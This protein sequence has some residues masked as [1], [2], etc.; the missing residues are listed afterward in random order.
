M[1]SITK[2]NLLNLKKDIQDTLKSLHLDEKEIRIKFLENET[3]SS[4]FWKD[5]NNA[6]GILSEIERLK[7]EIETS[8]TLSDDIEALIELIEQIDE[9]DYVSLKNDIEDLESRYNKFQILKF[10]S[11][12]Y[13]ISGAVLTIHAG[14]GGTEANDW[15][16]MLL[17]MYT[18]FAERSGWKS[19]LIDLVPGT[20]TGVS[21]ATLQIEGEYV[22]GKL[23]RETGTHRLVR[24]S[25]FNAQNLRQTSFAGIEVVPIIS[26]ND[27]EVEIKEE[28]LDIKAV[29]AGGAGG[30]HVNK[31]SSAIQ[32]KHIP[33]GIT[34]HSSSRREQL[35]NKQAALQILK[36]KLWQIEEEKRENELKNIKGEHKIAGWGNQ[37]RNYVLHPYKLVKDLRTDIQSSNPFDV[38]DGNLD[39]FVDAQTR[40]G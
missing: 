7:K 37:I 40:I 4:D 38:L 13:D 35:Q 22:F 34:V 16:S 33:T 31:T 12:K 24:L 23:K 3:L 6:K 19:E 28:D 20:E 21:S 32:L 1:E 29:R 36:A 14:Q 2:S 15:A 30:Q 8:K 26:E 11:G 18:R 10:M 5:Q 17:R 9:E 25:P 39:Q 27:N